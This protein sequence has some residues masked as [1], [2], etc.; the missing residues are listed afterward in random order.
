MIELIGGVLVGLVALSPFVYSL[1]GRRRRLR[2]IRELS[3]AITA[4]PDGLTAS[5]THL[6]DRLSKDVLEYVE[7]DSFARMRRTRRLAWTATGVVLG[8]LALAAFAS[9][10]LQR[11]PT[12]AG[13]AAIPFW[14]WT[15]I[16]CSVV[17][18]VVGLG[19]L[20]AYWFALRELRAE[21]VALK[22]KAGS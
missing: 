4:L 2:H 16:V 5:E 20:A 13:V 17:L 19:F 15:T 10:S 6:K 18:Y 21:K 7:F 22:A 12:G 14:L 1:T 9:A 8:S 11:V 3:D